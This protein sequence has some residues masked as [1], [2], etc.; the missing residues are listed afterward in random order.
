MP[1]GASR[2]TSKAKEKALKLYREGKS[3]NDIGKA[4]GKPAGTIRRWKNEDKWDSDI[5]NTIPNK[6]AKQIERSE[7]AFEKGLEEQLKQAVQETFENEEINEQQQ[8]FCVEYAQSNNGVQSYMNVYGAKYSTA[9]VSACNLLRQPKIQAEIKRLKDIKKEIVKQRFAHIE[10]DLVDLQF[11]IAFASL[12]NYMGFGQKDVDVFDDDTKDT[13]TIQ[14]NYVDLKNSDRTDLQLIQSV[15]QGKDGIT[16]KL[17]DEQK[18][19]D[20]LTKYFDLF[21]SDKRKADFDKKK[22]ELEMLRIELGQKEDT[23]D[24]IEDDGFLDCL[25]ATAGEVWKEEQDV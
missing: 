5:S 3:L 8:L 11:R 6:A 7:K 19:I 14:V 15:K 10:C 16:I 18:A 22:L 9:M 4:L 25:N 12:G 13:K 23:K 17:K 2:K 1:R 24:E 21:P 20:W